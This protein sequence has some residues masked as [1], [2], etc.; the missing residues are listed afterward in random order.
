[1]KTT[2]IVVNQYPSQ[3]YKTIFNQSSGLLIRLEDKMGADPF[4]CSY[5]PELMDI[6]IT[7][8]CDKGCSHCYKKSNVS[9]THLS[10]EKYTTIL[11]QAAKMRVFQVALGGGN[12]NQHPDFCKM[13][14][15]TREE[16]NIIPSYTTNG[17]GL[18]EDVLSAT[19]KIAELWP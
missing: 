6:S 11:Q 1:M 18:C 9:G 19:K 12:P 16:F 5:G 4:W 15:L 14:K 3:S 2:G 13:L 17:R 7:N 8:W 10:L